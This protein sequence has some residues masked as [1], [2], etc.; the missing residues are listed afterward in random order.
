MQ[1]LLLIHH[2]P[3]QPAYLRVKVRRRLHRIGA[4]ALKNSVYLLPNTPEAREDFQWLAQEIRADGGEA[5]VAEAD[6]ILGPGEDDLAALVPAAGRPMQPAAAVKT[7]KPGRTWVTRVGVFVDRIAS[8][9]LIRRSIDRKAR[10]KFV[11]ERGYRPAPGEVRFD[12][13][14]AEFTHEGDRCTFEVL[15]DR[16]KLGKDRA[17]TGIAEIVHDIDCKDEKYGRP[18]TPGVASLL[19]AIA[20][21]HTDDADRLSRGAALFEDLYRALAAPRPRRRGASTVMPS[22]RGRPKRADR[23]SPRK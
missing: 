19:Q 14:Q 20:G 1:Y 18:E 3:P 8:A 17:I 21:R 16:F 22:G 23:G 10:F 7:V 9:W 12:M 11:P 13:F 15:V 6:F 4:G 5:V 2:L